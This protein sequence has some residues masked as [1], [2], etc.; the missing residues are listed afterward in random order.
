MSD[1]APET[2]NERVSDQEKTRY[3]LALVALSRAM[4]E[5][6]SLDDGLDCLMEIVCGTPDN[7][8]RDGRAIVVD[9]FGH[10]DGKSE[11]RFVF[12]DNGR[13]ERFDSAYPYPYEP[14]ISTL[15]YVSWTMAMQGL[16]S[17]LLRVYA[18]RV[19][20]LQ[21]MASALEQARATVG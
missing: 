16:L 5:A 18:R 10:S 21:A 11:Y 2:P 19:G 20:R 6:E 4:T 3:L 14:P 12:L 9:L 17:E 1:I 8:A 7:P 15:S 13:A